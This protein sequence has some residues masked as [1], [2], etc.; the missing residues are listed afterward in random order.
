MKTTAEVDDAIK[1]VSGDN[2]PQYLMT[3][4]E[5]DF[6]YDGSSMLDPQ[7]AAQLVKRLFDAPGV[8]RTK[9][10]AP[11][12]QNS[13][14]TWLPAFFEACQCQQK[15]YAYQMHV[16][17]PDVS[18][19]TAAIAKFN[20]Q[21][22]DKPLWVTEVSPGQAH[23]LCSLSWDQSIAFMQGVFKWA[24]QQTYVEKMFWNSGNMLP[25][26]KSGDEDPNTCNSYLLDRAGQP[27]PEFDAFNSLTC[28]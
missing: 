22:N 2:P 23:P 21:F 25:N 10:I 3:F 9:I 14:G 8:D 11:G 15:F 6:S 24:Q 27:S 19:T 12:P 20:R 13:T 5:P 4:N 16:Y 18:A 17:T 26:L 28:S 7:T 1:L